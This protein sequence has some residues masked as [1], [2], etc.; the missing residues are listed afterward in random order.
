MGIY[1]RIPMSDIADGRSKVIERPDPTTEPPTERPK[2]ER[3]QT[4]YTNMHK[5]I[6][7][8]M[9][10]L[11]LR[12]FPIMDIY[13]NKETGEI[14]QIAFHDVQLGESLMDDENVILQRWDKDKEPDTG[15]PKIF[16]DPVEEEESEE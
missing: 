1:R 10:D 11:G 4:L 14:R 8:T 3:I 12:M 13:V 16:G 5:V 2:K 7:E 15:R 6:L 9:A